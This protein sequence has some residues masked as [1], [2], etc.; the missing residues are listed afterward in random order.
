MIKRDWELLFFEYDLTAVLDNQLGQVED[1]VRAIDPARFETSTDDLV[2]ATVASELVF[3]P[4]ELHEDQLSVSSG[5]ANVDV[6]H[7]FGRALSGPGP[8]Y[9]AGLEVTYHVP[10]SGDADLFKSKPNSGFKPNCL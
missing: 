2:S 4:I 10:F 1:K 8:H 6:S 5:D 3:S 7:D 9:V